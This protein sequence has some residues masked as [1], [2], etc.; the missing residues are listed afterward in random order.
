ML[1]YPVLNSWYRLTNLYTGQVLSLDVV[2]DNGTHSSG[3]LQMAATGNYY[4][5]FWRFQHNPVGSTSTYA[6]YTQFLGE[7]KR[8]DVYDDDKTKPHLADAGDYSGRFG[9]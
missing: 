3:I 1:F 8:L 4:G 2:N 9:R 5:E 7:G 6:L